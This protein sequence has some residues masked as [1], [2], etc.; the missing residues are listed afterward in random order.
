MEKSE[1]FYNSTWANLHTILQREKRS[2]EKGEEGRSE[3]VRGEITGQAKEWSW[4]QSLW[5]AKHP[6]RNT[7]LAWFTTTLN[8]IL[9][10]SLLSFSL[11]PV[12][13]DLSLSRSLHLGIW[14][15]LYLKSNSSLCVLPH[16]VK[17]THQICRYA[18]QKHLGLS[19]SLPS[20][21]HSIHLNVQPLSGPPCLLS[22]VPCL[23]A[24]SPLVCMPLPV[25]GSAQRPFCSCRLWDI[26]HFP[27][28]LLNQR[29][30]S[31]PHASWPPPLPTA[32][33]PSPSPWGHPVFPSRCSSTTLCSNFQ[34]LPSIPQTHHADSHLWLLHMCILLHPHFLPFQPPAFL[35]VSGSTFRHLP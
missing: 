13:R 12:W 33:H 24:L 2:K 4:L 9:S 11:V 15:L 19:C 25:P 20:P 1:T 35:P 8:S 14:L 26:R 27:S 23:L 21:P 32:P 16:S 30:I 31:C 6:L 18:S 28:L 3:R 17:K 10:L 34:N 29:P 7:G 5:W 22:P